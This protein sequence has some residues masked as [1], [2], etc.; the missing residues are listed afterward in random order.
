MGP[1]RST[2]LFTA[3]AAASACHPA[4]SPQSVAASGPLVPSVS[5][6]PAGSSPGASRRP[7]APAAAP[8]IAW[9]NGSVADAFATAKR[10]DK[11]V[12]LFW[13]AQWCPF[14]H[15]LKATVFPRPDFIAKT[16]LFIPVYLDGDSPGAQSW[17]ERFGVLGYPT[18]VVLDADGREILR[19]GAGRDVSEYAA[20]LDVALEDL[21]PIDAL[22]S[23]AASGG[24][25]SADQ[26]RRLAYN[27]WD[28]EPDAPGTAGARALALQTAARSC[29]AG[30][31]RANL[32]IYAAAFAAQ[33][34]SGADPASRARAA[35]QLA[36]LTDQITAMLAQPDLAVTLA[37]ALASLDESF[38]RAARARNAALAATL[39]DRYVR[40]MQRAAS[41]PGYVLADQLGFI[42]AQLEAMKSLS[43]ARAPLPAPVLAAADQRIDA[44]L[45]AEQSPYV[46][47]GLVNAA[48]NILEDTDQYSRAYDIV[49]AEIGRSDSP[50]Y[51]QADL[52]EVAEKLGRRTEA[53]HLLD[54]AYHGS[55]GPATR[56][57]WGMLYVSGLLRM[58]PND[59][60]RIQA[61]GLEVLG[62]LDGPDRIAA[63]ARVRLAQFD[64]QLRHWNAADHGGHAAVLRALRARAQQI[65]V[66]LP[67]GQP[68]RASCDA[69]L[70]P[71]A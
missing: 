23:L 46:R 2:L 61:A 24:A 50:Y 14:C 55:R 32:T 45:A 43:P 56:F 71:R 47:P 59:G 58:A 54:V 42:D 28:L 17:G 27:S 26:C 63:R 5:D 21:Q 48:L 41:D 40:V 39:R 30:D 33:A 18:L 60:G 15:T 51:F 4:H 34:A 66:T 36:H 68:E 8:E 69:F 31:E 25:L 70:A 10:E 67:A 11:P 6:L 65:C 1:V 52:A 16:R 57:Q 29:P 22:L 37:P 20:V 12:L 53:M 49:K 7:L 44:A 62:E 64:Q 9:F 35:A 3:I 13:G 38:F 19:L